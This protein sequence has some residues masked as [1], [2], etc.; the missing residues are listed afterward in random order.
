[1]HE[2]IRYITQY[3]MPGSGNNNNK[4]SKLQSAMIKNTKYVDGVN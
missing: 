1:M 4:N 2:T 3:Y